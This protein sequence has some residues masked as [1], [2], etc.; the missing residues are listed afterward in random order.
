M[1]YPF[2][3]GHPATSLSLRPI[4]HM[5]PERSS[6]EASVHVTPHLIQWSHAAFR[7]E[8]NCFACLWRPFWIWPV[9]AIPGSSLLPTLHAGPHTS[10]SGS[11]R[12]ETSSLGGTWG[13]QYICRLIPTHPSRPISTSPHF[14]SPPLHPRA[15]VQGPSVPPQPPAPTHPT[16]SSWSLWGSKSKY[17]NP[18]YRKEE[19]YQ[20][21]PGSQQPGLTRPRAGLGP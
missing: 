7:L 2:S 1:S 21:L 4:P 5:Q 8:V 11:R 16:R 3:T 17:G 10:T 6:Q 12:H 14:T 13:L 15:T 20:I 18:K 9:P 19:L